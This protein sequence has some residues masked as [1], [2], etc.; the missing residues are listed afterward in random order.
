MG[1]LS[2][3]HWLI[4]LA[5]VLIF[6]GGKGKISELMG[7][8]AKGIKSFKQGMKEDETAAKPADGSPQATPKV[9]EGG[10]VVDAQPASAAAAGSAAPVAQPGTPTAKVG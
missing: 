10:K 6:F 2:V 1:S 4:F 8:F 7:D 5:I 9:I 3:W